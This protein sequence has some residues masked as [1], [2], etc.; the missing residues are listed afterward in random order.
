[1]NVV[2]WMELNDQRAEVKDEEEW[3][4]DSGQTNE[5]RD[6]NWMEAKGLARNL[7]RM[8]WEWNV[9]NMFTG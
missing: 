7:K 1:M 9:G 3:M 4:D 2:R 5:S 8:V 6:G